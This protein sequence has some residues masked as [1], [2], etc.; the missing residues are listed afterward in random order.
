MHVL[1]PL[2]EDALLEML[3]ISIGQAASVMST[4]VNEPIDLHAPRMKMLGQGDPRDLLGDMTE[5]SVCAVTQSFLGDFAGDAALI[6]PE[7]NSLE[8]VQMMLNQEVPAVSLTDLEQDA[9]KE[10]GNIILTSCLSSLCNMLGIHCTPALPYLRVGK[11]GSMFH[12]VSPDTDDPLILALHIHFQLRERDIEG[13][14]LFLMPIPSF[15][16]IKKGIDRLL[17]T[18][19]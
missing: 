14:L 18:I 6:F 3:N 11:G 12:S 17:A 15:E 5:R 19:T 7:E 9:L 13:L 1:T 10:I 2:Q 8:I 4:M 16:H